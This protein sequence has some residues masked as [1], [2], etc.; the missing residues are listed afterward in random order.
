M[1]KQIINEQGK[2]ITIYRCPYCNS[3]LFTDLSEHEME[4]YEEWKYCPYCS[5]PINY[6]Y[7]E[8]M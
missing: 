8:V 1:K 6:D 4:H 2:I 5:T 7:M 3:T